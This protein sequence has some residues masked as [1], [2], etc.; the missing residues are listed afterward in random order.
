MITGVWVCDE[1][2]VVIDQLHVLVCKVFHA[3]K[4]SLM[5]TTTYEFT[6]GLDYPSIVATSERV[7]WTVDEVFRDRHFD[8]TKRIIPDSWVRTRHLE[9][10]NVQEQR[11]LNHIRAFS[12][13]HLFGNYEEF[14][15]LHLTEIVRQYWHD[16]RAH[17]RALLR[18]GE[19]EMKHQ[20]LFLR[21]ETVLEASCGYRFG[22][23][24]DPNKDRVTAFTKATL[25]YPPLPRFLLLAAFEWGSQRHYIESV[26]DHPGEGSDPLYVDIL[27]YHWIEENQHTKIDALEIEQLARA[28]SPDELSTTFDHIQG[29][30]GLVDATFV[31]QVEQELATFQS[32]TDRRLA[33]PEATALGE[34]LTQSMRAIFI[35]VAMTH[36]N[37]KR[38]ALELSKEGAAKLGIV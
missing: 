20:Q 37:F 6:R 17:L 1:Q 31:G 18:F 16:D 36:P 25:A 10:L 30:G 29:L 26:R 3:R 11:T 24:F 7:S 33:E 38:V 34:A 28:L 14:I 2:A 23:Y 9:F 19:E 13:V 27:Q 5:T 32:V 22:R 12:Y 8:A 4:E 35:E 15:P 21:A